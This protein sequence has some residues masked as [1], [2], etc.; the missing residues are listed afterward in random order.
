MHLL[1]NASQQLNYHMNVCLRIKNF[2]FKKV[3]N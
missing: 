3:S 1:A 2:I